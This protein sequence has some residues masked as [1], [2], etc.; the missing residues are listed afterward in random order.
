MR[1]GLSSVLSRGFTVPWALISTLKP[2]SVRT[3]FTFCSAACF[4]ASVPALCVWAE[5]AM[6]TI[7]TT[8]IKTVRNCF[9][10]SLSPRALRLARPVSFSQDSFLP[11]F[12]GQIRRRL[13][14]RRRNLLGDF[15]GQRLA[16]AVLQR[17]L[18]HD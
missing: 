12:P 7:T 15:P 6:R 13:D 8:G 10:I 14:C 4:G 2:S 5:A 17:F 9:R 18:E 3:T 1:A 11:G 16:Q